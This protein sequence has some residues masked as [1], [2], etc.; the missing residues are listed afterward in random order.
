MNNNVRISDIPENERPM[1]RML[2]S[3]PECLNNAELLAIIL[4]TGVRGE[5]VVALSSR[6]LCEVEGLDGLL[7]S[8]YSEM[9]NI[10]GI[11]K[12]K[13]SQLIAMVELFKRFKTLRNQNQSYKI[14][15]PKDIADMLMNEMTDLNQE[16]LKLIML[17]TKNKVLGIKDVFKGTLNSSIVHPREI[18]AEALKR[19]SANIIICHNHP[20]G[21]PS[22]S[23]EDIN[24]TIRL[25][26]CGAIMGINLLDHIIIGNTKFVS[27][28]EKGII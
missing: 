22:P 4:R 7:N 13:A 8:N 26:E 28:K 5:N 23:K 19:S 10:K 27:L 16:V 12:I 2:I 21:D 9:T 24:I 25:K 17:D 15:S 20:S 14:S 18:F 11:K 6:L 3:G 1:E